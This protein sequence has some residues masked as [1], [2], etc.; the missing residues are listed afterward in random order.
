MVAVRG[1]TKRFAT[2]QTKQILVEMNSCLREMFV[3]SSD[4]GI[5]N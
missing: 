3:V 2:Y 1:E 4:I 5:D